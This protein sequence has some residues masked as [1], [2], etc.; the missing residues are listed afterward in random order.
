L[1]PF[2]KLILWAV[3]AIFALVIEGISRM[4]KNRLMFLLVVLFAASSCGQQDIETINIES[5][6]DA[7]AADW[8]GIG[9]PQAET[10]GDDVTGPYELVEG[11]PQNVCGEGWQGGA[12]GGVFA[13]TPDRV[14]VF[15]RGCLPALE[16]SNSI[17]PQRN[18][19]R[20]DRTRD[21]DRRPRWDYILSIFNSDGELV[22][23][24]EQHNDLFVRPHR[25]KINPYDSERHVW[26]IDDGAQAVYKFTSD[27]ELVMTLGEFRVA[28]DDETHFGRP[29]DIAWLPEGDF[30]VSDG[31]TN[32]RVMKF[33]EDGQF[34]L[35]W[36]ER[37][38]RDADGGQETRPNH[39]N[40]VH[41]VAI[42]DQRRVYIADRANGRVQIFDENGTYLDEWYAKFPYYLAMS[43]DQHLWVSDGRTNK[44]L[45][46]DLSG[47]LLYSW[48]TFGTFPGGMWGP[49]QFSVDSEN[50][51]YVSDVHIGRVQKFRPKSGVNPAL[52]VGQGIEVMS[53][54]N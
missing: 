41:G 23:S 11:W 6:E 37:G 8:E 45:K 32:T 50:N 29:T 53:A 33:T 48:G 40:T 22:D 10:G 42:D 20:F 17:V 19:A 14:F 13:E 34:L 25:V 15:Q 18:T 4:H 27:G 26:L 52:L 3:S 31:Y 28:G 54:S 39:F 21:G 24:W 43:N 51:L 46:Y 38:E 2:K 36:G 7:L 16:P 1:V 47:K 12:V 30:F 9:L 49:H 44:I 5:A 35:Q